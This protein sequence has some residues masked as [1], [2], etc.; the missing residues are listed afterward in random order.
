MYL[1]IYEDNLIIYDDLRYIDICSYII[2]SCH[3]ST[4]HRYYYFQMMNVFYTLIAG[5][6]FGSV[7]AIISNPFGI[8]NFLASSLPGVSVV[9]INLF[10]TMLLSGVPRSFIRIIPTIKLIWYSRLSDEKALTIRQLLEGPYEEEV[11]DYSN[12]LPN[13]LYILFI[14]LIYWTIAPVITIIAGV[15]FGAYY[16]QYKYQFCYLYANNRETGGMYFPQMFRF[17]MQLLMFSSMVNISYMGLKLGKLQAPLMFP[18]PVVIYGVWSYILYKFDRISNNAS[19]RRAMAADINR[20][21]GAGSDRANSCGGANGRDDVNQ[22]Y[23]DNDYDSKNYKLK[24]SDLPSNEK[25]YDID[26]DIIYDNKE[27]EI[28]LVS[29]MAPNDDTIVGITTNTSLFTKKKNNNGRRSVT[30]DITVDTRNEQDIVKVDVKIDHHHNDDHNDADDV[31]DH[32][33]IDGNDN[34]Y[35]KIEL[36]EKEEGNNNVTKKSVDFYLPALLL[37]PIILEPF[38]YRLDDVPLFERERTAC[39]ID[40][41]HLNPIYNDPREVSLDEIMHHY[42]SSDTIV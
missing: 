12:E 42:Y 19:C 8:I 2:S 34:H 35:I 36:I 25:R 6:A 1:N 38:M 33:H 27:G 11:I 3:V 10:L 41:I 20:S 17:S 7:N 28:E 23:N 24:E 26:D 16:I 13:I 18:L 30:S 5:T 29:L 21:R 4:I 15:L 37:E 9:Y 22:A 14:S 40:T 32:D 39:L 31:K